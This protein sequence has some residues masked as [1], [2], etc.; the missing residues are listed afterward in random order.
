MVNNCKLESKNPCPY[1][2]V[3][4]QIHWKKIKERFPWDSCEKYVYI[5]YE[6][7]LLERKLLTWKQIIGFLREQLKYTASQ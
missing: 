1:F 5:K 6:I 3:F 7:Y 2:I 4:I